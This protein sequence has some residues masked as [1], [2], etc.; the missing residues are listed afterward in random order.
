MITLDL[1]SIGILALATWYVSYTLTSLDCPYRLCA[2]L[3][4]RVGGALNCIYCLSVWASVLLVILWYTD[5][6][7]IVY[8]FTIAGLAMMLR[9]FTGAGIND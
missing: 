8:P 7:M 3:R 4:E 9:S 5:L 6:Y 1:E 2:K